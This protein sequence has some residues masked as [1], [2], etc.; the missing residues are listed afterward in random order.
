MPNNQKRSVITLHGRLHKRQLVL[1]PEKESFI[2]N[3]NHLL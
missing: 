1:R 3:K 2:F